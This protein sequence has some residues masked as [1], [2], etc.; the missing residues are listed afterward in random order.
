MLPGRQDFGEDDNI[1]MLVSSPGDGQKFDARRR[2]AVTFGTRAYRG[3]G[4]L[5]LSLNTFSN[6]ATFGP[7]T[8]AQ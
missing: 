8:T 3:G 2:L 6:S 5:S 1:L 7:I 4:A